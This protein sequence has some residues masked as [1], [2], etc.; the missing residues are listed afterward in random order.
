MTG[1]P[2]DRHM[3]VGRRHENG[4]E[5]ERRLDPIARGCTKR[6][7]TAISGERL[8]IHTTRIQG[9]T[10]K[11]DLARPIAASQGFSLQ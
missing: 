11:I 10:L 2:L 6:A 9:R 7:G 4:N 5:A 1:E 3:A 8:N